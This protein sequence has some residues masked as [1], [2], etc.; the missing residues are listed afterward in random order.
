MDVSERL[1]PISEYRR[2]RRLGQRRTEAARQNRA[3]KRSSKTC[4]GAADIGAKHSGHRRS[5]SLP[6]FPLWG[7]KLGSGRWQLGR[8][9][10]DSARSPIQ[11]QG[12]AHGPHVVHPHD[13]HSLIG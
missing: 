10:V 3:E 13:L 2:M 1:V 4:I 11:Q 12:F 9:T 5:P 8:L 7:L 6:G